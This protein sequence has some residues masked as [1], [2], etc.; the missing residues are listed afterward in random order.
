[1]EEQKKVQANR[2]KYHYIYKTTCLI[3]NKYYIGMHSTDNLSDGYIGSGKKLWYSIN[4]YGKENHLVEILEYH[5]TRNALRL[6]EKQLVN[7]ELLQDIMCMNLVIGGEGGYRNLTKEQ[8]QKMSEAG[9]KAFKHKMKTDENFAKA[10]KEKI[11]KT[12]SIK[13]AGERNSQYGFRWVYH[14][15]ERISKKIKKEELDFYLENGWL[16]GKKIPDI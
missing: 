8:H 16:K 2:R 3:N 11:G 4:K 9:A 12:N 15:G 5:Q 13:Q 14:P 10:F 1:M 6:R 7:E